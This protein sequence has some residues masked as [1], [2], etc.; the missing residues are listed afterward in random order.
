MFNRPLTIHHLIAHK[1]VSHTTRGPANL[2]V[3][4]VSN[5]AHHIHSGSLEISP[6]RHTVPYSFCPVTWSPYS[7]VRSL[8]TSVLVAG[9]R[10][11]SHVRR[12]LSN[13]RDCEVGWGLVSFPL[14]FS[15]FGGV[16]KELTTAW[17]LASTAAAGTHNLLLNSSQRY[18][19]IP[20]VLKNDIF[21]LGLVRR[22]RGL[23]A[24][25]PNAIGPL[26]PNTRQR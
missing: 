23:A 14:A 24:Y 13:P 5:N 18:V 8:Y 25:R 17:V 9:R 11:S 19:H 2:W 16:G 1:T 3:H 12:F 7:P 22:V 10:V 4:F 15:H 6:R 21:L 26:Q 20:L